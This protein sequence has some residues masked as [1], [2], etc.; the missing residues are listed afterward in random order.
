MLTKDTNLVV[1]LTDKFSNGYL[2]R[3]FWEHVVEVLTILEPVYVFI[4]FADGPKPDAGK[5]YENFRA[6]GQQILDSGSTN[7]QSAHR[8]F[9]TQL[10]VTTRLV[11][12]HHHQNK[13]PLMCYNTTTN[14]N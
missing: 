11:K 5:V 14:T 13:L 8:H 3:L 12:F 6:I 2:A 1:H 4:R 9:R 7:A 10:N